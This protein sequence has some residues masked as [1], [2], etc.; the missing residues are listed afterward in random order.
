MLPL[1]LALALTSPDLKDGAPVP[2]A[3]VWNRDG[4][5]GE[6]RTPA[7]RWDR[8]PRGTR[9]FALTVVDHD[10]PKPGGWVHWLVFGIPGDTRKLERLRAARV[11]EGKNDFGTLGWGGPCPPPGQ[12]HHYT[13][14]LDALD[15]APHFGASTTY[16]AYRAAVKGHVLASARMV[17]VYKR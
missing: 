14:A 17:P 3:F 4:C 11:V 8:P 10:A 1:F 2:G 5:N 6:N 7:L 12:L 16:D 13:F 15:F 9:A